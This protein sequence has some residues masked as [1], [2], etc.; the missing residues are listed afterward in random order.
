MGGSVVVAGRGSA[1]AVG[2]LAGDGAVVA[3][4]V[5]RGVSVGAGVGVA[6]GGTAVGVAVGAAVAVGGGV[7]VGCGVA[8]GT[9]VGA[10]VGASVG[11]WARRVGVG[12]GRPQAV[13]TD[14]QTIKMITDGLHMEG[15][16]FN[17]VIASP[18]TAI[19]NC[20]VAHGVMIV[21]IPVSGTS[22]VGT[23]SQRRLVW[24]ATV[25]RAKYS[26]I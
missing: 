17:M 26:R 6:V 13:M 2:V 23:L 19:A 16:S 12:A 4:K 3:V 11:V 20:T 5:G 10:A 14:R 18:A 22:A 24:P 21:V 1:V 15:S 25:G 7:S 9:A 8:V